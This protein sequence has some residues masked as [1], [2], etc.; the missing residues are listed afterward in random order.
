LLRCGGTKGVN[1]RPEPVLGLAFGQTRGP[2]MTTPH[3]IDSGCVFDPRF[4]NVGRVG[5]GFLNHFS[6]SAF[7]SP[8][9]LVK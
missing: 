3:P 2:T 6:Y 8:S 9:F 7:N 1:G 4:Q 5:I